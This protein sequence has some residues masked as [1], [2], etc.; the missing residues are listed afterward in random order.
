MTRCVYSL[1][2]DEVHPWDVYPDRLWNW[3]NE[4]KFKDDVPSNRKQQLFFNLI[5]RI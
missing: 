2:D 3:K 1:V 5:N 4:M